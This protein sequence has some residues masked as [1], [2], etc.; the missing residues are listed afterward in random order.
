MIGC[1]LHK[2]IETFRFAFV[3]CYNKFFND[4]FREIQHFR[5]ELENRGTDIPSSRRLEY[6]ER[7]SFA[8]L[9]DYQV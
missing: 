1:K 5:P 4:L 2:Y 8:E 6:D 9:H 3:V 7:M